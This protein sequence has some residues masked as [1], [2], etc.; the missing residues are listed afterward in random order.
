MELTKEY[1]ETSILKKIIG[2]KCDVC[3]KELRNTPF[4][5]MWAEIEV[6]ERTYGSES[7]LSWKQVC[8]VECFYKQLR[9][10]TG[11]DCY[12]KICGLSPVFILLI[13]NDY[14][15]KEK[16]RFNEASKII[17]DYINPSK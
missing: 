4:P 12:E 13:T 5:H 15:N 9:I 1:K 11:M 2:F 8:S 14:F 3:E 10:L 17:M 6:E 7:G 16:M